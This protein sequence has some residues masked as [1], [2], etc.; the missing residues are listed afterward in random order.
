MSKY[1]VRNCRGID[2]CFTQEYIPLPLV[3][4]FP[5]CSKFPDWK[6]PSNF[7]SPSGNPGLIKNLKGLNVEIPLYSLL[8]GP[9][10]QRTY[11]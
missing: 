9:G 7:S 10:N 2:G 11:S 1:A 4:T 6:M 5:V 3:P 8:F